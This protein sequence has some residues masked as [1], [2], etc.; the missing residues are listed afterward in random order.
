MSG[1]QKWLTAARSQTVRVQPSRSAMR[2][3]ARR[4][5]SSDTG[6]RYESMGRLADDE[7]DDD[8]NDGEAPPKSAE[9]S[10]VPPAWVGG[11]KAVTLV[12]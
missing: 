3:K 8:E 6:R 5:V 9:G 10:M 4:S 11:D 12:L 1:E 2:M 7:D